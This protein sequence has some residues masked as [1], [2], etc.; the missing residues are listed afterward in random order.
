MRYTPTLVQ[1]GGKLNGGSVQLIGGSDAPGITTYTP[2]LIT[3]PPMIVGPMFTVIGPTA[4]GT[5]VSTAEPTPGGTEAGGTEAAGVVSA[6]AL[7]TGTAAPIT[8][9]TAAAAHNLCHNM[10]VSCHRSRS[11][12]LRSDDRTPSR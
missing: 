6:S 10:S 11:L 2:G 4:G 1:R 3:F 12:R 8:A 7:L 5:N 9:T